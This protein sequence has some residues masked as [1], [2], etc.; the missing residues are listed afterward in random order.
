[1]IEDNVCILATSSPG[2]FPGNEVVHLRGQKCSSYAHKT[3]SWYLLGVLFK[4]SDQPPPRPFYMGA[5]RGFVHKL[6]RATSS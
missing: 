2:L 6:S 1:M 3:G 5:S 4:I